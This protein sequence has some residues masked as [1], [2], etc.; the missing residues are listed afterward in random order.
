MNVAFIQMTMFFCFALTN[1]NKLGW[2]LDAPTN[3][4]HTD[5]AARAKQGR[6]T[7]AVNSQLELRRAWTATERGNKYILH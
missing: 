2:L 3:S 5:K 7:A 4:P 1:V 6:R